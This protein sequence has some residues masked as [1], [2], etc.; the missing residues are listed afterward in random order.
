MKNIIFFY[1]IF[2]FH[3]LVVKF[4]VYLNRRVFVMENFAHARRHPFAWPLLCIVLCTEHSIRKINKKINIKN[5][6]KKKCKTIISR[7]DR[8]AGR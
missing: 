1:L 4:S 3:F 6:I 7:H 2:F 8:V 5:N